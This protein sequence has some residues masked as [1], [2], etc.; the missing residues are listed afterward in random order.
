MKSA[1]GDP[2]AVE[3]CDAAPAYE[4]RHR[5]A[6]RRIAQA[7]TPKRFR[8]RVATVIGFALL[9]FAAMWLSV[10]PFVARR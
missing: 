4:A 5:R 3:I 1:V 9:Q 2:L 7:P 10:Q 6:R 8:S